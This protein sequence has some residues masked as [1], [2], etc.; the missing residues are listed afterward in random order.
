M[1]NGD[2][3]DARLPEVVD[4]RWQV[5][6]DP[7][8]EWGEFELVLVRSTWDYAPRREAF[9]AWARSVRHIVNP[10][11]V[12]EWNTDKRYLG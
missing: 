4:G 1:P 9:L 3:D 10:P 8:A 7:T 12:L 5:W 11:P 6:D 2:R